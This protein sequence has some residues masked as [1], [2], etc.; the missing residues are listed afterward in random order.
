MKGFTAA[1]SGGLIEEVVR[2]HTPFLPLP[3]P[4]FAH[5]LFLP[6]SESERE[7]D[8]KWGRCVEWGE[9]GEGRGSEINQYSATNTR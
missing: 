4:L 7:R 8:A 9:S 1:E 2:R 3:P 5:C 6:K